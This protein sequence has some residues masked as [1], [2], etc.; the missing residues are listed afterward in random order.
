MPVTDGSESTPID[1]LASKTAGMLFDALWAAQGQVAGF[2][3]YANDFFI[4]QLIAASY[5][6]GVEKKRFMENGGWGALQAYA[7]LFRFNLDL[8][9]RSLNATA[10]QAGNFASREVPEA[11][12]A[13]L[14]TILQGQGEDLANY[15]KRKAVLM[16]TAAYGIPRSLDEIEPEYGFHFERGHHLKFDETDRF[17]LYRVT[18][19]DT[20]VKLRPNAKPIIIIP[21]YVLG[22]NILSFL[23]GEQRSYAHSFANQGIPTY[24][25]IMKEIHDHEAVQ[26]MTAEDD[27]RDTRRFCEKVMVEH[28]RPVTLNGYC[29]GGFASVCNLASGEL[30]GLVDALV[31]CVSPMDGTCSKGLKQF[32]DTLPTRFNDLVYGAKQLPNGNRVADG[33]LMGWVYKLKSIEQ[34]TPVN[35]YL[36]DLAMLS[37]QQGDSFKISKSVAALNYWLIN[38]RTDLPMK[39]TELSFASYNVPVTAD[40]ELP[41]KLFGRKLNFKRLHAKGIPWLICYGESDDLVEKETAL[42]PLEHVPAEVTGFPKGHVAIATSWSNPDSEFALHKRYAGSNARG[43]VKF[44]LDLTKETE[45]G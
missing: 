16:Q 20:Q 6:Q 7:D 28:G 27:T 5:V 35:V 31:T 33:K 2:V 37:H 10:E 34:E 32:L 18:P 23:P 40:G 1:A 39:I 15:M 22:P 30:D 44:Q 42:A 24:I 29:Q 38:E 11:L 4:P 12:D 3:R 17:S 14:N 41:V 13:L 8:Y 45:S 25:R 9:G 43:P 19:T 21:P 36:R 26:T